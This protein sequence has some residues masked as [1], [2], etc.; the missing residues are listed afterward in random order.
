M[1]F[2]RIVV[3]L[4]VT[5]LALFIGAL[6]ACGTS[7]ATNPA[8]PQVRSSIVR[9]LRTQ[10]AD[11]RVGG[12]PVSHIAVGPVRLAGADAHF[13]VTTITPTDSNGHV[14]DD[15][16]ALVLKQTGDTWSV[17]L[18]PGT[19]F[20]EECHPPTPKPIEELMCPSPYSVLGGG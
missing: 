7:R 9:L 20:P 16:A 15:S 11:L 8:P 2:P 4:E 14:M 17:I 1:G 19:A 6:T 10:F 5:G 13:A 3:W 12:T 18:G